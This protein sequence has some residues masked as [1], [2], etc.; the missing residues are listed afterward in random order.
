VQKTW[1][2]RLNDQPEL[3]SDADEQ[4]LMHIPF[5]SLAFIASA[6]SMPEQRFLPRL[7]LRLRVTA[8][9]NNKLHPQLHWPGK[10]PLRSHLDRPDALRP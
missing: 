4:L 3:E 1:A 8:S 2:E 10:S 7:P 9:T 5:V 6:C